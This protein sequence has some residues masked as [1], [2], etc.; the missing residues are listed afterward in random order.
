MA[1]MKMLS[2]DVS[3][4]DARGIVGSFGS[5]KISSQ[6]NHRSLKYCMTESIDIDT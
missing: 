2:I 6:E 3:A 5:Q 1:K 4:T